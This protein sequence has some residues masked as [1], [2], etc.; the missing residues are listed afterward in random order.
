[1]IYIVDKTILIIVSSFL[2]FRETSENHYIVVA[3]LITILAAALNSFF[4]NR[5]CTWVT[6]FLYGIGSMFLPELVWMV[7]VVFFDAFAYVTVIPLCLLV[8]SCL[9]YSKGISL[10]SMLYLMFGIL[11]G[12]YLY[13]K[14]SKLELLAHSVKKVRDDEEERNIL[15]AEKNRHLIEKQDQEVY[16]ATLKER[17]RIAREIHD[18]VGHILTRTILQMG[19]LMTIYKEEP[20]YGQLTSVK[21]NL[22]VAMNNVRES[23]HDLHDES[24]DLSHAVTEIAD[25]LKGRFDY[26]VEYD[27][28]DKVDRQYKYAMI[29]IIRE[30][31]SNILKHS[32][33]TDVDIVLREHPGMYQIIVH[34]YK[35]M[36]EKS[37]VSGTALNAVHTEVSKSVG[38]GL[39]NIQDRVFVLNGHVDI[40]TE[41]GFRIFVTLPRQQSMEMET[42]E[43]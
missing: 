22:D 1:M 2:L 16:V 30:G 39:Q 10:S 6:V 33:N 8:V 28:H 7:P 3:L 9:T 20:L 40:S 25:G 15:L 19:A 12:Y 29:G 17:N 5:G 13:R 23:V 27:I 32:H 37:T 18:N 11:L 26:H 34:D 21:E 42:E 31:V 4:E 43:L 24:V 14:S 36:R 38:I 35:R 41:N